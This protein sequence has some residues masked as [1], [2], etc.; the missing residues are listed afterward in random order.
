[1]T[2][3]AA[4]TAPKEEAAREKVTARFDLQR[5]TSAI[6]ASDWPAAVRELHHPVGRHWWLQGAPLTG[7]P[8]WL[9][10]DTATRDAVIKVAT[11]FLRS[12]PAEP[13]AELIN[14]AAD[15]ITVGDQ[16]QWARLD[17]DVLIAWLK[18]ISTS[19]FY[20]EAVNALIQA[21]SETQQ[22]EVEVL[23]LERI[24][25][26]GAGRFPL[27]LR[28]LGGFGSPKIADALDTVAQHPSTSPLVVEAALA[29]LIERTPDRG[30]G[31]ALHIV[32]RRPTLKPPGAL[33][34]EP[35]TDVSMRWPQSVHAC[36]ALIKSDRCVGNL[37]AIL[38]RLTGSSQFAADVITAAQPDGPGREPWP[39]LSPDQ[40]ATLY[41]WAE[42]ALPHEPDHPHGAV[43]D[44]NPVFEFSGYIYRRLADRV[45][46]ESVAALR[47]IA[48][49]LDKPW[50]RM[51][52]A[53]T[54]NAL[55][56]AEWRP[57]NPADVQDIIDDPARQVVTTEAQL[58]ALVLQ[59]IDHLATDVQQDPDVAAQFWH[60]QLGGGWMPRTEKQFTTLLTERI[61]PKLVG[62]VLRQE[63]QLNLRYACT[64]GSEPDIEAIALYAGKEISV[65]V[66]VKGIWNDHVK[67]GI[68]HQLA[69]RYLTGARS[70]T[71]IYLVAAFTSEHWVNADPRRTMA[72]RHNRHQLRQYLEDEARRLSADGKAV[73]VRVLP[74]QL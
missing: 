31:T 8:G 64:A 7:A 3:Q 58:A 70:L 2:S 15:A 66:E 11:A 35:D 17:P 45:D 32:D 30:V 73:H 5:L 69:N 67:T 41:V 42:T 53:R 33:P 22:D 65:F 52:A 20:D 39:G 29:A 1:M 68:E 46:P 44:V 36:V 48:E 47:R 37:D 12:L 27:H 50:A 38:S 21:V 59:A 19:P 25:Q 56:E 23:L 4:A 61:R 54:A 60:Q 14:A 9:A 51:T 34:G 16:A 18:A 43:V 24:V 10:L 40:L 74:L 13:T 62:M 71:G 57:L 63:V 49:E 28:R 55:Q 72:R 26:D 6:E